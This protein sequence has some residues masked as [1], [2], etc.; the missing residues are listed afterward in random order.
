VAHAG[1]KSGVSQP[2]LHA[3]VYYIDVHAEYRLVQAETACLQSTSSAIT[4]PSGGV[5]G[6]LALQA[7]V[8]YLRGH[9]G[10]G[11]G[12]GSRK[13]ASAKQS[14]SLGVRTPGGKLAFLVAERNSSVSKRLTDCS[15]PGICCQLS[16]CSY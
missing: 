5:Y 7:C 8:T 16:R 14:H 11:Y 12:V 10:Q 4:A 2:I 9:L 1:G 15:N 6:G 3:L 13:P